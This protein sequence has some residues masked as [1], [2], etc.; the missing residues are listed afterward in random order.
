VQLILL[1]FS[2]LSPK[3]PNYFR[4]YRRRA[5]LS[6]DEIAFLLGGQSGAHVCHYERFRRT[7]SLKTALAFAA[8]FQTPIQ[9]LCAGEHQKAEKAVRRR[10]R[11]LSARL[12]T[13]NPDPP[14]ARK[15]AMLESIG[16]Q[17]A[18]VSL[19]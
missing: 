9:L 12:A 8:I 13:E 14:T 5:G 2:M 15:L 11:R 4:T 6:Q 19:L 3:L 17:P 16:N 18:D 1:R 10:A 7:P